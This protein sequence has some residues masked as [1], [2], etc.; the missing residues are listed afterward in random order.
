M[1]TQASGN[2]IFAMMFRAFEPVLTALITR[3]YRS[4]GG[5]SPGGRGQHKELP[6]HIE[7]KDEM[8]LRTVCVERILA[9]G[10]NVLERKHIQDKQYHEHTGCRCV[11]YFH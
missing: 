7:A 3:H 1:L 11:R 5:R 8:R 2:S 6:D 4:S 9:R 10:V